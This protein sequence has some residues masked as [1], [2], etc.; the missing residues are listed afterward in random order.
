[1]SKSS[2]PR[3]EPSR[4]LWVTGP[5]YYL[6]EDGKDRRDLQPNV[7][8]VPDD[9]W[10]CA[11]A[12]KAG[13][14]ALLYRSTVRKD[15][16]YFVVVRSDAEMLDLPG[17]KFHGRHVC[18]FEVI[19]KFQKPLSFARIWADSFL[20]DWSAVKVK[21]VKAHFEVPDEAWTRLFELLEEDARA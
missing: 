11:P 4:W 13:D 5:D 15:V 1:M 17:S 12:T 19:E 6:D 8:F 2:S 3:R 16:A 20:R 18:Q 10:T 7:G 9:W 14:L 21:L